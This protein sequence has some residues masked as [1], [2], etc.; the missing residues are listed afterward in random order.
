MDR[1]RTPGRR[2]T[3][4]AHAW[5][6]L[7][8]VLTAGCTGSIE[9]HRSGS[10]PP[11]EGARPVQPPGATPGA[12]G[13]PLSG[14]AAPAARGPGRLR[15]LP[16]TQL[17]SSLRDLLGEVSLGETESDTIASGFASV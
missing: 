10:S 1:E 7:Q 8:A 16:R 14:G 15:L 6:L 13:P 17:Q 4:G 3:S 5:V 11:E 2:L 9:G 12:M